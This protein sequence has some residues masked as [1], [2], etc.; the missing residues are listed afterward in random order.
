MIF[1]FE[2]TIKHWN[3]H[4][5]EDCSSRTV[6]DKAKWFICSYLLLFWDL[7]YNSTL[8]NFNKT[9]IEAFWKYCKYNLYFKKHSIWKS[10]VWHHNYYFDICQFYF[11]EWVTQNIP[12]ICF[13]ICCLF[14]RY[15]TSRI[16]KLNFWH[17]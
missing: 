12:P 6:E 8:K 9:K 3:F 7:G 13:L 4:S 15:L 10:Q 11:K 5:L 2:M 16:K 14:V 17:W 1:C